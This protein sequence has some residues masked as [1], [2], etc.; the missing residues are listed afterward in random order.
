MGHSVGSRVIPANEYRRVR[1]RN[2]LG[3][4]REICAVTG[5]G[6]DWDWRL[7]I[8]EIEQA[9]P[10]SVFP[11]VEREQVLLR[12]EG[13]ELEFVDGRHLRLQPPYGRARFAGGQALEA[14][15]EGRVEVFNLMWRP[16]A[17][18]VELLHR[19]L[20]GPM[21]FFADADTRWAL[22][23]LAGQAH[24]EGGPLP[25][26]A[27]GDTAVLDAPARQRFLLD[28]GGELLA[29]RIRLGTGQSGVDTLA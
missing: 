3:W 2:G 16:E 12:G 26:L 13:L 14:R 4:T 15:P 22:H 6:G 7:S 28:G 1:W 19:P 21:L 9:G 20:V 8:A 27:Q 25:P 29:I 23:L 10:Y 11:G 24:F 18:D 17:V 5:A